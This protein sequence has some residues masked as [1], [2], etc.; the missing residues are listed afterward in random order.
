V[1][2][3]AIC[4][5]LRRGVAMGRS[6]RRPSNSVQLT[7]H[8]TRAVAVAVASACWPPQ[9]TPLT[10]VAASGKTP[11]QA[12][13]SALC[14]VACCWQAGS[15]PTRTRRSSAPHP[16]NSSR[17]AH[18]ASVASTN[19]PAVVSTERRRL[20]HLQVAARPGRGCAH[21][22]SSSS[23]SA[24]RAT[25]PIRSE[26]RPPSRLCIR[27]NEKFLS[28]LPRGKLHRP[29]TGFYGRTEQR[30]QRGMARGRLFYALLALMPLAASAYPVFWSED[31]SCS[32]H[33]SGKERNHGAPVTDR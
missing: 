9:P 3:I 21:G 31:H 33:P 24:R 20:L 29:Q 14:V 28:L 1:R 15:L 25:A 13:G 12:N 11:Q 4:K 10:S 30:Q 27:Y 5:G 7:G 32:A 26:M 19:G 8:R 22:Q 6:R 18:G 2:L 17:R 16:A 23:C